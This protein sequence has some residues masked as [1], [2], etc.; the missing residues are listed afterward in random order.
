MLLVLAALSALTQAGADVTAS[1]APQVLVNPDWERRPTARD[2]ARVYPR[3][4]QAKNLSGW[5]AVSCTVAEGGTLTACR[6]DNESPPGAGFGEA[7]LSL[8]DRFKMRPTRADGT[9]VVGGVVRIPLSFHIGFDPSDF[10]APQNP[11]VQ[12]ASACYG[13]VAHRLEQNPRANNGWRAVGYWSL[14]VVG[15]TAAGLA[16][17]SEYEHRLSTAHRMAAAGTLEPPEGWDLE[18]CL[19]KVP[20]P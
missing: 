6:V 12:Q 2:T 13:Q 18:A 1:P 11:T 14:Q 20:K 17:P 7:T 9:S 8:M 19:A 15:A 5:A 3:A 4:A 16:P 10:P